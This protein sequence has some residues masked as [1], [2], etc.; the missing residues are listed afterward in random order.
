MLP[1][2]LDLTDVS[3]KDVEAHLRT[4]AE[5]PDPKDAERLADAL[6]ERLDVLV[7]EGT[8]DELEAEHEAL[9][10]FLASEPYG[11]LRDA[12]LDVADD[13]GSQ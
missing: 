12:G 9:R 1:D 4:L 13:L 7:R 5:S 10:R 6:D 2:D 8:R 3:Y 11:A